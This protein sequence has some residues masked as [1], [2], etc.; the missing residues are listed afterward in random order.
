MRCARVFVRE[1][2]CLRDKQPRRFD[3]NQLRINNLFDIDVRID[4]TR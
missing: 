4:G 2:V 3:M 1:P